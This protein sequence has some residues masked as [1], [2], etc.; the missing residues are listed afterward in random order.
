LLW[1]AADQQIRRRSRVKRLQR[2][3]K[4]FAGIMFAALQVMIWSDD[5]DDDPPFPATDH[6][7]S[8]YRSSAERISE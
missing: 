8:E 5:D 4:F 7:L 2:H 3:L 1:A 6:A